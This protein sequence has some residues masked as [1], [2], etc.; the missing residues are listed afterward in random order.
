[1]TN[2]LP[3]YPRSNLEFTHGLGSYLYTKSGEKFLDFGT[4]IAVNSLGYSNPYLN[5]KLKEQIDKLWHLSNVYQIPEQ[6]KLAKRLC[7]NSFADYVFFCNSGTEAIEASIKIA[8]RYFH[9]T[10]NSSNKK[11]ILSFSGSFHGRTIG[12][13]AA[14]G[15]DKLSSFNTTVNDF[16][17]LE[18]G[19]HQQ[20]QN[21]ISKKTAAVIIE[22][23]QGEG[24]VREVPMQCLEGLRKICDENKCLL[25]FDE[26]QCGV[27]RTGKLFAYE[28]SGVNPDIMTIAKAIGNGFPLGACLTSKEVGRKMDFGSHGSTFGGNP[29]ACT[30]GNAVLDIMLKDK[31]F[32]EIN[33]V[34]KKLYEGLQNVITDFPSVIE[35][36]RGKGFILGLKCK[37][38][39]DKF[40]NLAREKYILT[41]KASDNVV[42]LLP[43]INLT[44]TECDEAIDKI[45]ATC[46]EL[47]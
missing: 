12:A 2:V 9:D 47:K 19:D 25:I 39:N 43:P 14:G 41:V 35:N 46:S 42:R 20:L 32:S 21:S 15:P 29:L 44:L 31:F 18:F 7:D 37:V 30:V 16:K 34:A 27:G 45:R 26:V 24:G 11:E 38:E 1:M 4:G 17:F 22:P 28:W 40:V 36:I 5:D 6:E 23:I 13:L 10:K 3:T 33:V 8:R